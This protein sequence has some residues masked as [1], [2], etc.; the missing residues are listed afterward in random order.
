VFSG[1]E[2]LMRLTSR[3]SSFAAE[4]GQITIQHW[5]TAVEATA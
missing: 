1:A 3:Y 2:K 4:L 5:K